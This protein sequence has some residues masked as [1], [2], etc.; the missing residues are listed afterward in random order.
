M[1]GNINTYLNR[2][3]VWLPQVGFTKD[4]VSYTQKDVWHAQSLTFRHV[5]QLVSS[6]RKVADPWAGPQTRSVA[7]SR[8]KSFADRC[9]RHCFTS[10]RK[11]AKESK[12]LTNARHV[13][14]IGSHKTFRHFTLCAG[15]FCRDFVS[16][17][18]KTCFAS[19]PENNWIKRAWARDA[20]AARYSERVVYSVTPNTS[21][22]QCGCQARK[23][24]FV[25]RSSA[26]VGTIGTLNRK[27]RLR[28][29]HERK[30]AAD[31]IEN[32]TFSWL[33]PLARST[34]P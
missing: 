13:Q 12:F 16:H 31:N 25:K 2:E 10:L 33:V 8:G 9:L 7:S 24:A 18:G 23:F 32:C 27:R 4:S 26:W 21:I 19:A 29:V 34:T 20:F 14:A 15:N 11:E 6:V 1:T 3:L 28:S 5:I 22:R 30:T 17:G